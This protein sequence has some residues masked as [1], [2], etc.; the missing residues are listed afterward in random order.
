MPHPQ[1][2]SGESVVSWSELDITISVPWYLGLMFRT[3]KE[4]GVLLE[5]TAGTSSRLYLQVGVSVSHPGTS[6]S[7]QV[8][9]KENQTE[10]LPRMPIKGFYHSLPPLRLA[11]WWTDRTQK[12]TMGCHCSTQGRGSAETTCNYGVLW[13]SFPVPAFLH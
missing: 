9:L 3:R 8:P 6:Q 13:G 11:Q 7:T 12:G 2:F 1:R 5:A 10:G 4:D